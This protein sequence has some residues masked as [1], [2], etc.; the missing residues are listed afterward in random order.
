MITKIKVKPEGRP[1][2]WVV[3]DKKSLKAFIRSKKL[4]SIHNFIQ[5]NLPVI[6]GSSHEV[7][8]VLEDIDNATRIAITTD[9]TAN[10]GHALAIADT[11]LEI[12]DI[13]PVTNNDLEVVE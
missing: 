12:Y 9:P 4:K 1:D 6:V 7:A 10:M 8:S 13:G 11:E 5:S 2:L 3:T